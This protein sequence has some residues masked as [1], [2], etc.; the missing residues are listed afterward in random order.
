LSLPGGEVE[1]GETLGAALARELVEEV[2]IEAE[3]AAFKRHV[4]AI[5]HEG[6]PLR[7]HFAI[8]SFVARWISGEARLSDEVDAVDWIDRHLALADDAGTR[9]GSGAR[10]ADRKRARRGSKAA[11]LRAAWALLTAEMIDAIAPQR[12]P[13]RPTQR[14]HEAIAV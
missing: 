10:G 7:L 1:V 3:I 14:T 2:G 8:A 12:R 4:E 6:K 9:R 11:R 5:A 13:L